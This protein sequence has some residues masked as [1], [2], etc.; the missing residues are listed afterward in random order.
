[1]PAIVSDFM[2]GL[3]ILTFLIIARPL[4]PDLWFLGTGY[5]ILDAGCSI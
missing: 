4:V 2:V 5:S 3:I 1:M